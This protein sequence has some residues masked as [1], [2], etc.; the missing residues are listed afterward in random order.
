MTIAGALAAQRRRRRRTGQRKTKL[1][2]T[3]DS[4][5]DYLSVGAFSW[6]YLMGRCVGGHNGRRDV[7]G[8]FVC[9][10]CNVW[11]AKISK[12]TQN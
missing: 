1:L 9:C 11:C 6:P 5:G 3:I 7:V 12:S 10:D 8:S 4:R 2:V